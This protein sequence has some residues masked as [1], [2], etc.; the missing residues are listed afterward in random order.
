MIEF[1][2]CDDTTNTEVECIPQNVASVYMSGKSVLLLSNERNIDNLQSFEIKE[3]LRAQWAHF[4]SSSSIERHFK[5]HK[6]SAVTI[7]G[8]FNQLNQEESLSWLE[9]AG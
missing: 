7:D 8:D 4:S 9:D 1:K 5:V 2:Y 6:D 3:S